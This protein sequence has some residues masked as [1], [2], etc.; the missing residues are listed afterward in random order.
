MRKSLHISWVILLSGLILAACNPIRHGSGTSDI[1]GP[2]ISDA[3]LATGISDDGFPVGVTDEFHAGESVYLWI[4]WENFN[5]FH[6]IN[7]EW[8]SPSGNVA[9]EDSVITDG[10]GLRVTYF[11]IQTTAAC[12]TG[13]WEVEIYMDNQ[14]RRSL[15]FYLSD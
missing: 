10:N 5:D 8:I 11:V 4:L 2:Y 7:V 6:Q 14:F 9:A 15:Y 13:E 3:V 1:N 12:E